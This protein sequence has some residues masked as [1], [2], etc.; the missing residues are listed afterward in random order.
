[1]AGPLAR[2][3]PPR[4]RAAAAAFLI[5]LC[6]SALAASPAFDPLRGLSIDVLTWLRW[7]TFGNPH[8]PAA[9]PAVVVAFDEETF[10][11]PPFEG[12]PTVTWTREI[13]RVLTA[14]IDGGATVVGFD[15]VFPT[16]IE[17]S[18]V[19]FGD[20]TLGARLRGFDRD[21]LRALA[22]GARAG[23]VVLGEVQHQDKPLLPAP[24]Q[25]AAVGFGRNIRVLNTYSD[26]DGV[27]RRMPLAFTVDGASAPSLAAELAT[28]ASGAPLPTLGAAG[29]V[30]GTVTLNFA[31]GSGD[32]PSFSFADLHACVEK[33]DAGFFRRH[34]AGKTVLIG[35]ILDVED[36]KITSKRF[37]TGGDAAPTERCALP[38]Q[39]ASETFARES[40]PGV[41]I[42]A[43][44][45]NNL[46]RGDGLAEFSRLGTGLTAFALAG[47]AATAAFALG[48]ATAVLSFLGIAAV[49]TTGA[50]IAFR[51]ALVLPL[52]EPLLS[53]LAALGTTIGYRL[54]VANRTIAAQIAQR[55]AHEAEMAS[56]AAIQRAMLPATEP[57]GLTAGEFDLFPYMMP[58]K[59]VGGDLYDI[60]RLDEKR[61]LISIGDV[62]GKGIPASLFMAITQTVMRLVVRFGEDLQAEVNAANQMLVANNTEKMFATLFCGVLD[63]TSGTMIYCNCGHNP[64]LFLR[65]G[66]STFEALRNQGPPLAIARRA[67]YV[68]RSIVLAPGDMLFLYTDGVTE[69]E[70]IRSELFGSKRLEQAL[71]E[72]R[73]E[74][75]R[76]VVEHVV[77]RVAEFAQG[78]PPSDDLTC[79]AL[80]RR[81]AC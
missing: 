6:V 61:L 76:P 35:S 16:S 30:P 7:R 44:A 49:W 43:T 79:I 32:I 69:A 38:V 14:L 63:Q 59:E 36:R 20:D 15:I 29:S 42:H 21:F 28:R 75:A 10:R 67:K 22:L 9:S 8:P 68:P 23:K 53:A 24:G 52:F 12:T 31:G 17:Q 81:P 37:A 2:K 56:A 25:R 34:F 57:A 80:V 13:G 4:L 60:V 3:V 64:P 27:I 41:Y 47:L 77:R 78:A 5:A 45:I 74:P 50:T 55:R 39:P 65:R 62:C 70:N 18:G 72:M 26:P 73:G 51:G 19:P 40:I 54:V 46:L 66:E 1:M 48:P 58:A 71:L 33:G 11:T